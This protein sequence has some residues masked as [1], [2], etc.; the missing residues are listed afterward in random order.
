M[1]VDQ[2]AIMRVE[3]RWNPANASRR[4]AEAL[5]AAGNRG[6]ASCLRVPAL[7]EEAKVLQAVR[8]E[9]RHSLAQASVRR[10]A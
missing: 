6:L 2:L 4:S 8:R 5:I 3:R 9:L 7:P 1:K 10:S